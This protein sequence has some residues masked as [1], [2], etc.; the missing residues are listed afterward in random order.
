VAVPFADLTELEVRRGKKS[1]LG[2]GAL[3]GGGVGAAL[4]IALAASCSGHEVLCEGGTEY[5]I[6]VPAAAALGAGLG[7]LVGSL[8]KVD[9]WEAVP[10]EELRIGPSSADSHGME[11]LV[12][13][14]L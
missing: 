6:Y 7:A 10:V 13:L 1:R 11:V 5:A 8:I 9:R 4:G 12:A 2:T 3:I 14:R